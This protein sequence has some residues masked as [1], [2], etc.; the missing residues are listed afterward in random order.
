MYGQ[1]NPQPSWLPCQSVVK[2]D[3]RPGE[4]V[5]TFIREAALSNWWRRFAD[6]C[7]TQTALLPPAIVHHLQMI[8]KANLAHHS[9]FASSVAG[10]FV[11]AQ[12]NSQNTL[13][14]AQSK[15]KLTS[16]AVN[17]ALTQPF[18]RCFP[19][20]SNSKVGVHRQALSRTTFRIYLNQTLKPP[21][22]TC[23]RESFH[24]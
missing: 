12:T 3:T 13:R 8:A 14:F 10:Q 6:A 22:N 4:L 5:A 1:L 21:P 20:Y 17:A 18:T 2:F 16:A 24:M 11:G 7:E 9:H 23:A 15:P 19:Y